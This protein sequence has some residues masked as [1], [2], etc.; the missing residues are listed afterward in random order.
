M[1]LSSSPLDSDKKPRRKRSARKRKKSK[2]SPISDVSLKKI[3]QLEAQADTDIESEPDLFLDAQENPLEPPGTPQSKRD[4]VGD[5]E[6]ESDTK[7]LQNISVQ[8]SDSSSE[9]FVKTVLEPCIMEDPS[10]SQSQQSQSLLAGPG[11]GTHEGGYVSDPLQHQTQ[12]DHYSSGLP[13]MSQPSHMSQLPQGLLQ[14]AGAALFNPS[15]PVPPYQTVPNFQVGLSDHDIMKIAMQTKQ[16]LSQE[17]DK[18]VEE[19]VKIKTAELSKSVESLQSDN[20]KLK[21]S[22]SKLEAKL[23]TK[24]DDLE[25]YSRR[26]CVRIAGIPESTN[27]NTD[28]TVLELTERLN[29]DISPRDI[30][31]SHR[32]GPQPT[33]ATSIADG[34]QPTRPREIIVKLK[35]YQARLRLLQARK[36]LRD[37]KEKVY[38][39]EDLTKTR[40]SLAFECRKL[41][42]ERKILRT[43]VYDGNIF[44]TERGGT[45]L[46]VTQ[47]S[48]LDEYRELEVPPASEDRLFPQKK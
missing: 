3:K 28:E 42:R 20:Q 21:D 10:P 43:W 18:L 24:M 14:P 33:E 6:P 30:D 41:R 12:Q 31:R 29:I 34:A 47:D 11:M 37:N 46:K 19:K 25:Q 38:I 4:C 22:I 26:S 44:M 7:Q 15:F 39:N 35:S 9:T 8:V 5:S 36:T 16:L 1:T 27:E 17:I 45:K 2:P 48:E 40:K 13:P 32:V 23:T